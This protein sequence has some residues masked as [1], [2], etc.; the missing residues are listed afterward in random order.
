MKLNN[1]LLHTIIFTA[2]ILNYGCIGQSNNSKTTTESNT[3]IIVSP[4]KVDEYTKFEQRLLKQGLVDISK[5]DSSIKVHLVYATPLNFMGKQLY[6]DLTHAFMLPDAASKLINAS[7]LLKSIRPDLSLIIYDAARPISVQREMWNMVKG[8]PKSNFVANPAKGRG[9]HNYGAAVDV[10]LI[11]CAGNPIQMGSE[12][13]YFGDAAR[14]NIESKLLSSGVI[15]QSE[16]NNRQLLRK[17]MTESGFRTITSEWW[18]FNLVSADQAIK[19]LT[20]IE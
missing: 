10:T 7:K 8:T 19:T 2:A 3:P 20:I 6:H 15:T 12:Y 13:D 1:K 18:H 11:D 16:L 4:T 14:V 9:L 17:V 5:L